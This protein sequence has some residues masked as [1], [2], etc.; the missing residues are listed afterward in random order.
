MSKHQ[1]ELRRERRKVERARRRL[2]GGK[3]G[4]AALA[5]A[6]AIA[7]G[8]AAYGEYI[9]F[10]NPDGP[11][12]FDWT[13]VAG[14]DVLS[15]TDDAAGQP[16]V[17][18]EPGAFTRT[19]SSNG[20]TAVQGQFGEPF[21]NLLQADDLDGYHFLVGVDAEVMIPTPGQGFLNAPYIFTPYYYAYYYAGVRTLLPENE[22]TYL[23][24]QFNPGDGTHYGWIGVER[25]GQEVDAFAWGYETEVGVSIPAGAVPEPGSLALLAFGALA[26]AGRRRA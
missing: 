13:A 22:P 10:E 15:V 23:G 3:H 19:N 18:A 14:Q 17:F 12:H 16:G 8:T 4:A 11:G 21:L 2:P 5:A 26:A 25:T 24:V 6:V 9:R 7:G 1:K 20:G